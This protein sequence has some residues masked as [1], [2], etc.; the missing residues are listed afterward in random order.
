MKIIFIFTD[1]LMG[2][3]F[4]GNVSHRNKQ[5]PSMM[6]ITALFVVAK[7]ENQNVPVECL[8]TLCTSKLQKVM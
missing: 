5:R 8:D 3:L 7:P 4:S 1:Y 6:L 2:T